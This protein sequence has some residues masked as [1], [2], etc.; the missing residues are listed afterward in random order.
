MARQRFWTLPR[1]LVGAVLANTLIGPLAADLLIPD[2]AKQHLH[3]PNWPPHAK[4]HDAQY[5]GMGMLT[6]AMGLRI[7]LR[8]KGDQRAQFYLAAALGSVTWLGMWGA[9]LFP[10]TAAKDPEFECTSHRVL[11]MDVQLFIALVMLV[12]LSAAVGVERG[13]ARRIAG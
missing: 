1:T 10:G 3:N 12:G 5:V 8:R 7:L 4:F 2:I 11:G 6:G 9:L 13:R